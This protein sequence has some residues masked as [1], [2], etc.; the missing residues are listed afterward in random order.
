MA[1]KILIIDPLTL[2]GREFIRCLEDAPDL[3]VEV[4]YRHT[5][6]DDEHQIAELGAQT[7]PGSTPRRPRRDRRMSASSW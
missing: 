5:S 2:V 7:G 1:S 3:A 4:D 6:T